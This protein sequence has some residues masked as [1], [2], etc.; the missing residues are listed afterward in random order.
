MK[1]SSKHWFY[2]IIITISKNNKNNT[3]KHKPH[4]TRHGRPN[5]LCIYNRVCLCH[6]L[7]RAV[8]T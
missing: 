8:D 7:L 4:Y 6:H 1:T 5:I 2:I 3:I